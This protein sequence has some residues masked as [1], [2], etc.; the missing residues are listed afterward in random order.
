MARRHAEMAPAALFLY[1]SGLARIAV[2]FLAGWSEAGQA[3][4]AIG[5]VWGIIGFA[6]IK[7]GWRWLAWLAFF[8]ALAGALAALWPALGPASTVPHWLYWTIV[9]ADGL[10]ALMLF[11]VLWGALARREI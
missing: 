3:M 11:G 2:P 10:A 1:V 5:L 6:L 4:A 8:A 9:A 7:R